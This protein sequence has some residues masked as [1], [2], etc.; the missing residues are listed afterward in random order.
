MSFSMIYL[1]TMSQLNESNSGHHKSEL[2][3]GLCQP[4]SAK[5]HPSNKLLLKRCV[6]AFKFIFN[7]LLNKEFV[8]YARLSCPACYEIVGASHDCQEKIHNIQLKRQH[9]YRLLNTIDKRHLHVLFRSV[10]DEYYGK[11]AA[12][13]SCILYYKSLTIWRRSM[14]KQFVDFET[15]RGLDKRLMTI[16]QSVLEKWEAD[17]AQASN[18]QKC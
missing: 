14:L 1:I 12:I 5:L 7:H 9:F 16:I 17:P 10:C 11:D 18:L 13:C 15:P 3:L 6:A 2:V 4:V 8:V